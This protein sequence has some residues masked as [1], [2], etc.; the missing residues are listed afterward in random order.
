MPSFLEYVRKNGTLPACL[1]FSLAAL[2]AFYTGSEL[3]EYALIGHRNG[4]E[5]QIIDDLSVLTFFREHSGMASAQFVESFLAQEDF[6]GQNL[7]EI[8]GLTEKLTEHLDD[9]RTNGMRAALCR[10]L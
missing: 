5:Y 8:E 6:F 3:R 1:T 4:N 9:I 7:N 2:M 10:I